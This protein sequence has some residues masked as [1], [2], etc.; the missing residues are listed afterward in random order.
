MPEMD[1]G[2]ADGL[3]TWFRLEAYEMWPNDEEARNFYL[4]R[5][6]ESYIVSLADERITKGFAESRHKLFD[7]LSTIRRS[8]IRGDDDLYNKA[9]FRNPWLDPVRRKQMVTVGNVVIHLAAMESQK[10]AL[11]GG[12]SV[13]KAVFLLRQRR[14]Y[15]FG[16]FHTSRK[17]ILEA[18]EKYKRSCHLIA[19]HIMMSKIEEEWDE[20]D[21]DEYLIGWL[22][23]SR[24]FQD[25]ISD[26]IPLHGSKRPLA[27]HDDE[28]WLVP[29]ALVLPE[30]KISPWPLT[31]DAVEIL[32]EYRAPP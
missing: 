2:G 6:V 9:E 30:L 10:K 20:D 28:V 22:S 24:Y 5:K 13:R 15:N 19:A 11:R 1:L 26:L 23:L 25:F 29:K 4:R 12:T 7:I 16:E 21:Q 18:L 3:D 14:H 8:H 32:K 31:P 27:A 17:E